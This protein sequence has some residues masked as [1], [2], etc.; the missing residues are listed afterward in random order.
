MSGTSAGARKGWANRKGRGASPKASRSS[1]AS[2]SNIKPIGPYQEARRR[3]QEALTPSKQPKR[4]T[5]TTGADLL[6]G[7]RQMAKAKGKL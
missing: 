1:K 4:K 5:A 6:K 2:K 3:R 7:L